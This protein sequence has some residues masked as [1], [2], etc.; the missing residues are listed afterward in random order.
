MTEDNARTVANVILGAAALGVAYYILKTPSLRRLAG[1]AGL[2]Q[3]IE[4]GER[5]WLPCENALE[6]DVE[7]RRGVGRGHGITSRYRLAASF[8]LRIRPLP[9]GFRQVA[10][11]RSG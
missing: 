6:Q 3:G 4:Q 8:G 5:L 11:Q 10:G 7:G 2:V 9:P 1:D